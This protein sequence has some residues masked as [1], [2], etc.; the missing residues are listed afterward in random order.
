MPKIVSRSIAVSDSKDKEEYKDKTSP[1]HIFYCLCG[2]MSLILDAPLEILPLRRVDGARVVDGKKNTHKFKMEP[3][4]TVFIERE[5]KGIEKQHRFKCIRC[6]LP[7][8]YRHA[9]ES[10]VTF[11]LRGALVRSKDERRLKEVAPKLNAAISAGTGQKPSVITK[12][13]KNMGKFSSVTVSTIEDEEDEIE[14]REIA[15]SYAQNA[16][17]IEKQLERKSNHRGKKD[18][19]PPPKKSRGTLLDV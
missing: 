14:A 18:E 19:A 5:G 16:K 3:S 9:T 15:D 4:E 17:I 11:I 2:Q 6:S 8:F 12:H 7:L 1:L 10:D 13:T